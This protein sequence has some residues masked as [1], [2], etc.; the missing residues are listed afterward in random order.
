MKK[1]SNSTWLIVAIFVAVPGLMIVVGMTLAMFV[2]ARST[3]IDSP[4]EPSSAAQEARRIDIASGN[5]TVASDDGE[6]SEQESKDGKLPV[7][8]QPTDPTAEK[9]SDGSKA[10]GSKADSANA[11]K[12]T[13]KN[14]SADREHVAISTSH[15]STAPQWWRSTLEEF[16]SSTMVLS[17][18]I[19]TDLADPQQ[20]EQELDELALKTVKNYIEARF[21]QYCA[22]RVT[23]ELNEIKEQLVI[24]RHQQDLDRETV[25]S[26]FDADDDLAKLD[27]AYGYAEV[28][29]DAEYDSTIYS[30]WQQEKRSIRLL[31][32]VLVGGGILLLLSI[33]FGFLSTD[34][35]TR[36]MYTVR[37]Q[38]L[39]FLVVVVMIVA[40]G[41]V[42]TQID[43]I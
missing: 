25:E 33:A 2:F 9:N 31:Q 38:M 29:I 8:D 3:S 41:W 19:K 32:M 24:R 13:A 22:D 26:M 14:T 5:A 21:G 1:K 27:Y 28:K 23:I 6:R 30:R 20:V 11:S 16:D 43:W 36:G 7:E 15:S 4:F 34:R 40:I 39:T 10:D 17:F 12:D 37:L 18:M 42:A 35:A